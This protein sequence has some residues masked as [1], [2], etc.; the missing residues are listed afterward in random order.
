[1]KRKKGILIKIVKRKVTVE[2]RKYREEKREKEITAGEKIKTGLLGVL[3]HKIKTKGR[4][5]VCS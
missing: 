4:R 2:M 1:M 3:M 5:H